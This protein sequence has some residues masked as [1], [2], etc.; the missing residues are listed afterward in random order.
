MTTVVLAEKPD[1]GRKFAKALGASGT[2]HT[3]GFIEIKED[4]SLLKDHTIVTWGIGHLVSLVEPDAYDE[5]YKKWVI[6]DLPIIPE[7]M[8]YWINKSTRQQFNIVKEQLKKADRIIIATDPDREGE[9]IAY[10]IFR[11]CG[12]EIWGKPKKRLWINSLQEKEIK[13]GFQ[14]LRDSKETFNFF[15]EA[16]TRQTADW[17]IG[18]NLTRYLSLL[19]QTQG[20]HSPKGKPW[21]VGRVQTPTNSLICQNY[22]ERLNFKPVP[23]YQLVGTSKVNEQNIRFIEDKADRKYF[24]KKELEQ[25]IKDKEL[26]SISEV[27]IDSVDKELKTKVAPHLFSLGE[28]Q[29]YCSSEF[30][31]TAKETLS[32]AQSLYTKGLTSYP[33]TNSHFITTNEFTYLLA[34]L[35]KYQ[36][37]LSTHFP[38][39]YKEARKE[40]VNDSKVK[41]HY[42]IIPTDSFNKLD[43]LSEKEKKGYEVIVRRTLAIFLEDYQ[44]NKTTIKVNANGIPFIATGNEPL[45]KGWK[46]IIS[47]FEAK[48][49]KEISQLPLLIKGQIIPF[50]ITMEEKETKPPQ[51]ITEAK[52]VSENGLM[53]KLNLGTP[54]TRAEIIESLKAREYIKNDG[55]TKLIPT[56]R[57]LFL[58]EYTKNLLIGSPE[59]TAKWETYLKGIG[60]G[61]AKAAPFVDR[62]KKSIPSI[63]NQLD[64]EVPQI[65]PSQFSGIAVDKVLNIGAYQVKDKGKLYEV[66]GDNEEFVIWKTFSG[67]SLKLSDI[68]ELLTN[69]KTSTKKPLIS[70]NKKKFQA[71]LQL[72][73]NKKLQFHYEN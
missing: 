47:D 66:R 69:G 51:Q 14:A 55:K 27:T 11:M 13:R 6:N 15:V 57:G 56:D 18:M 17:L 41:E 21:S 62:I 59:M 60:E 54:A 19:L 67:Y 1:Q 34:N 23:Y 52:L 16:G 36:S 25:I 46:A 44:H 73:E 5:K 64:Q 10:S 72:N 40:Y 4:S 63:F 65:N 31:W 45:N 68:E 43:E 39:K 12:K 53:A 2:S 30:G 71:I 58:Y 48:E 7:T 49:E 61:Q 28:F 37:Y 29:S 9:N 26:S 20:I 38:I 22:L 24:D 35:D 33:R 3:K 70:K 8:K 42:A 50:V 32:I